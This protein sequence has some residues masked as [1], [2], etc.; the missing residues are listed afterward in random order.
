[1]NMSAS[2]EHSV[3]AGVITPTVALVHD[4]FTLPG[5]A[6]KVVSEL[7]RLCPQSE[8]FTVFNQAKD[9]LSEIIGD[10]PV[11]VSS[12][13]SLPFVAH[14]YRTLLLLALREVERFDLSDFDV[15]VSSSAAISKGVITNPDQ[16]HIAYIHSPARYAWD[17]THEYMANHGLTRGWRG[18][19]AREIM[20]QFRNWDARTTN[21]VDVLVA[22]SE[23]VR[24]RIWK[25]YRRDS[26]VVYPPVSTDKFRVE[27]HEGKHFIVASR[28]VEYKR[29]DLLVKAFGQRP[30]LRLVVV[31]EGPELPGLK[32]ISTPN[33]DFVGHV[34]AGELRTLYADARAF[35]FAAMEDFGIAPVEAQAA[36]LPVIALGA[37]GTSETVIDGVTGI[38]F[39][40]QSVEDILEALE[41]FEAVE[42]SF[43]PQACIL[44]A[45]K[46]SDERFRLEMKKLIYA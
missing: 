36:G 21:G 14:Y 44:H 30:D 42:A 38:L 33:I 31:G 37:G 1:M 19:V 9:G 11:H 15:V 27:R 3:S 40:R 2:T 29:V 25:I 5:G 17:L 18:M 41:R 6:E 32:R 35:V 12:L 24:R 43:D 4:W 23:F 26:L 46:F 45:E 7:V 10:R 16:R 39:H 8:V 13:N 22:N 20:H 34:S 28:L